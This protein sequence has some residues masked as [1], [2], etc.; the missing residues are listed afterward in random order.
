MNQGLDQKLCEKYPKIFA[1]RNGKP[2]ETNM[3]WGFQ[4]DDGW[5][6]LIDSM[7]AMIQHHINWREQQHDY[8]IQWNAN[9]DNQPR[10]VMQPVEQVV[11]TQVKEKFG[12]LRFYY[13][14]GDEYIRGMVDFA[15]QFSCRICEVTGDRGE[16]HID[17]GVIKTLSPKLIETDER[18]RLG[19]R[20][21]REWREEQN[22]G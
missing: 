8:D 16:L 2:S 15:E 6:D 12:G 13:R 18:Y 1:M 9:P 4:C 20:P 11:A 17:S 22:K 7:C 3:C 10:E 19:W 21:Y 5:Y 14:G